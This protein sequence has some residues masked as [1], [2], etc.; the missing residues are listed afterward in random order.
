VAR[1]VY[2]YAPFVATNECACGIKLPF[3]KGGTA[4]TETNI[5]SGFSSG[6]ST[7]GAD[8]K[9]DGPGVFEQTYTTREQSISN[10]KN[11]LLTQRGERFMQPEFGTNLQAFIFEQDVNA[12]YDRITD[13]IN[14]SAEYWTPYIRIISIDVTRS[15]TREYGINIRI[16]FTTQEG[17][18][19]LTIN[20]L[21]NENDIILSNV[22]GGDNARYQLAAINNRGRF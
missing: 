15:T 1:Q 18:G 20:V 22:E 17:G 2:R 3:N 5:N 8:S 4:V 13:E 19:N 6:D 21:A 12:L 9:I 7:Y 11:L 10:F 14:S 16:V